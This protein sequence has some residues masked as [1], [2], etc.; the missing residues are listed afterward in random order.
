[1][2][3]ILRSRF[4]VVLASIVTAMLVGG[5]AFVAPAAAAPPLGGSFSGTTTHLLTGMADCGAY[6]QHDLFVGTVRHETVTVDVCTVNRGICGFNYVGT[7]TIQAPS[8]TLTGAVIGVGSLCGDTEFGLT[9]TPTGGTRGLKHETQT[10]EFTGQ[11]G[12]NG[13]NVLAVLNGT[14]A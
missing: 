3:T 12:F 9:L 6:N 2:A 10:L 11:W 14:L 7:F 5:I 13:T 1:M 8:G 4:F